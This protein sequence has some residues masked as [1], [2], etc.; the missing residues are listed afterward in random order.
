MRR[1]EYPR[2]T[3]SFVTG[4]FSGSSNA[5]RG[6]APQ[7]LA[8]AAAGL[9]ANY[10]KRVACGADVE[11][12]SACI[13]SFH[14]EA[15][16]VT[17][18]IIG[19]VLVFCAN[20]AY[21]RYYEAKSA[22][23]D[24]Y[25]GLRNMHVAFA[26]FLRPP[27]RGE[28]GW[29]DTDRE[30]PLD[31]A[32]LDR[33]EADRREL[34]RLVDVL[35]A[36]M[37]QSLREQ[38][39]GYSLDPRARGGDGLS[40]NENEPRGGGVFFFFGKGKGKQKK[41]TSSF[42]GWRKTGGGGTGPVPDADLLARDACGAPSLAALLSDAER[43]RYASVDHANRF[44][45]VVAEMHVVVERCRRAGRVYEKAAFDVYAD[46]DRVLAAYKTCERIVTTPIPYQYT[47]MVN[48]VLFFFVFSAPFIFTVTFEWLTPAPSAVLALGFYGI[49]EVGKTMMDPFDWNSPRV[50]L[51]AMGR[52]IAAEA[53]RIHQAAKED[54]E[55]ERSA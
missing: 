46:C 32:S 45:V 6:T 5:L 50:D 15:H 43:A 49:W 11:R 12:S 19:F 13:L 7:V 27:R 33:L 9:G 35:F 34:R 10:A 17:G 31:R 21:T 18:A 55:R 26:A 51:T 14:S 41:K 38:R 53:V 25:H 29:I 28:P 44:N 52:R 20:I 23:G 2:H 48:L 1:R 30:K 39:H 3:F 37:R 54:D 42:V 47:H 8:A 36:F 40:E 4:L 22:V 24:I 16:A